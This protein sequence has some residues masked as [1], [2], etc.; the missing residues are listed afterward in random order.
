M[1]LLHRSLLMAR[2]KSEFPELRRQLNQWDG[3]LHL[4][5][6]AWA[7]FTQTAIQQGFAETVKTCFG[8]AHE[9]YVGGNGKMQN[10]IAVSFLEGLD[11]RQDEWAWKLLTRELKEVVRE[12]IEAG[13]MPQLNYA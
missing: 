2:L 13:T 3:L 4:E 10:A 8:I 5:V 7:Q 6:G 11:L 1:P 9:Y 12:L